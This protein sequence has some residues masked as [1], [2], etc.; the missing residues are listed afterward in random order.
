[1]YLLQMNHDP[2]VVKVSGDIKT[3][4]EWVDNHYLLVIDSFEEDGKTIICQMSKRI[5]TITKVEYINE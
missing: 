2:E 4:I 1:M 3:L 5:G